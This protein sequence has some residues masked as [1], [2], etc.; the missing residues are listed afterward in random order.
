[1]MMTAQ[2]R[3]LPH[4]SFSSCLAWCTKPTPH[5]FI[6]MHREK[7]SNHSFSFWT[8]FLFFLFFFFFKFPWFHTEVHCLHTKV[9][10][11]PED[12]EGS[13]SNFFAA[14]SKA[15]W[16]WVLLFC[17]GAVL[18]E[19]YYWFLIFF[20]IPTCFQWTF[21]HWQNL[22][23]LRWKLPQQKWQQK[24]TLNSNRYEL[25]M[26]THFAFLPFWYPCET[27]LTS[28]SLN[29]VWKCEAPGRLSSCTAWSSLT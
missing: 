25:A 13:C 18:I 5:V 9:S 4:T 14:G 24:Q 20:F 10:K 12:I 8:S 17:F 21:F 28:W 27:D 2:A 3:K 26:K 22:K 19:C 29:L 7:I 6:F 1:M 16:K 23:Y 11:G 15:G